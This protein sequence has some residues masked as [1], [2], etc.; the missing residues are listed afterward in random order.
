M[1]GPHSIKLVELGVKPG[2]SALGLGWGGTRRGGLAS[3]DLG[4]VHK[5]MARAESTCA[6]PQAAGG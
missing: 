2:S 6:C 1:P 5:G 4:F 3:R